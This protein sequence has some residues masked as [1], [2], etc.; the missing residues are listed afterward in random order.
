MI[1][2]SG[3]ATSTSN[4]QS[5][6]SKWLRSTPAH[7]CTNPFPALSSRFGITASYSAIVSA[8]RDTRNIKETSWPCPEWRKIYETRCSS[9][10][11]VAQNST[12]SLVTKTGMI[13]QAIQ[14]RAMFDQNCKLIVS[15]RIQL[16]RKNVSNVGRL[17]PGY[18]F[19]RSSFPLKQADRYIIQS[20]CQC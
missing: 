20:T 7:D 13:L 16:L 9:I 15:R 5:C 3:E 1:I 6:P 14:Q 11:R 10:K 19:V 18:W 4:G 17:F 2:H 12:R 8:L